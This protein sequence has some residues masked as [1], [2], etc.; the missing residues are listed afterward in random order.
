VNEVDGANESE[1]ENAAD[2]PNIG[3]RLKECDPG[4]M[5]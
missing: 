4:K 1:R 2:R 5:I 3:G